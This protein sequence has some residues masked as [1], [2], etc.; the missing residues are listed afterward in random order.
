[1]TLVGH[2]QRGIK[3]KKSRI[4]KDKGLRKV[5]KVLQSMVLSLTFLEGS[6][7]TSVT[8]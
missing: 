3:K 4:E 5:F 6:D 2:E 1:M 8:Y 7:P